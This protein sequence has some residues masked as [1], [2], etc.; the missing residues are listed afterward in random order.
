V[1]EPANWALMIVGLLGVGAT[2][3]TRRRSVQAAT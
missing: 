1:P 3:R 2:R